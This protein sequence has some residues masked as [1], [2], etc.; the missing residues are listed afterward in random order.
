MQCCTF[1]K[2]FQTK[3]E[4]RKKWIYS[5]NV[6]KLAVS[7]EFGKTALKQPNISN[8]K[9]SIVKAGQV[10]FRFIEINNI[11]QSK[12]QG[13]SKPKFVDKRD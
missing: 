13:S 2:S 12:L 3:Y 10:L 11:L 8:S 9:L 6:T 5:V 1:V 7:C 4:I